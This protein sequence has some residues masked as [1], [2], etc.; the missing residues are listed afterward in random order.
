ML[1]VVVVGLIYFAP[2]TLSLV[3]PFYIRRWFCFKGGKSGV[4]LVWSEER[5]KSSFPTEASVVLFS[6]SRRAVIGRREAT[7]ETRGGAGGWRDS[8]KWLYSLDE[9]NTRPNKSIK[10]VPF[11]KSKSKVRFRWSVVNV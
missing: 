9:G 11:V 5:S 4:P 10:R 1:S 6:S 8:N 7:V 3:E 2:S